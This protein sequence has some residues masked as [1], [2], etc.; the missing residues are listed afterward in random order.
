MSSLH[1][2]AC[3]LFYSLVGGTGNSLEPENDRALTQTT[4][5]LT[6]GRSTPD[7]MGMNALAGHIVL[8]YIRNGRREIHFTS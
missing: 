1:D 4:F 5:Q 6:T 8:V 2:R 3:E 7:P